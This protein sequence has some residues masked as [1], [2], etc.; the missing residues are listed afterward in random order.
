MRRIIVKDNGVGFDINKLDD[1]DKVHV[2]LKNIKNRI[3]ECVDGIVNIE[4][5]VGDGTCITITI[6]KVN[7][8]KQKVRYENN[9]C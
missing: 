3:E 2:G 4:S 1:D 6:P 5:R 9:Y 8:K 7:S